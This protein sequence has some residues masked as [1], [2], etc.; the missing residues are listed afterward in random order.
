MHNHYFAVG[1]YQL[2]NQQL[3]PTDIEG[4]FG[5]GIFLI[6]NSIVINDVG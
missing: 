3:I 5:T 4:I 1:L 6:H 2:Q